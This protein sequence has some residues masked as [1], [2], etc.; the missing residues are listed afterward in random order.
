MG[1]KKPLWWHTISSW[2]NT[3]N[4][5]IHSHYSG[6]S[7]PFYCTTQQ[8]Q[9]WLRLESVLCIRFSVDV[10]GRSQLSPNKHSYFL[11]C[12]LLGTYHVLLVA[13]IGSLHPWISPSLT[14]SS[15]GT[16]ACLTP[17]PPVSAARRKGPLCYPTVHSV[18]EGSLRLRLVSDPGACVSEW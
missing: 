12:F 15:T 3:H 14:S 2:E 8:L 17:P 5:S 10:V 18:Q 1:K 4:N 9:L 7:F 16:G 6:F 11:H 13:L